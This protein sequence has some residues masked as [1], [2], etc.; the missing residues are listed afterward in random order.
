M[1][2]ERPLLIGSYFRVLGRKLSGKL[3][4]TTRRFCTRTWISFDSFDFSDNI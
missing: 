3:S 2:R 4:G 1:F